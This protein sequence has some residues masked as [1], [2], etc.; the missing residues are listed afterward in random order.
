MPPRWLVTRAWAV[1]RNIHRL[2]GGH[3]GLRLPTADR[4]GTLRITATGRRTGL[5][6]S[7]ILAYL[8][9]GADLVTLATNGWGEGQ[10]A[11]W[12]NLQAHP[13][14]LVET[15]SGT[16]AMR[17]RAASVTET[18]RLWPRWR[19][20]QDDLDAYAARRATPTPLVI[21]SPRR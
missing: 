5:E 20:V 21:L 11:W 2:T 9:D 13:D 19:E 6:R 18:Q 1:H 8:E 16:R 15:P 4:R 14:A 7:V 10:P 17:A 12:L 3:L